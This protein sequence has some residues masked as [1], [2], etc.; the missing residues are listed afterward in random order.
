MRQCL[1]KVVM[2][3]GGNISRGSPVKMVKTRE[4][5]NNGGVRIKFPTT[6]M[7]LLTKGMIFFWDIYTQCRTATHNAL[8]EQVNKWTTTTNA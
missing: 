2:G 4:N 6:V 3:Q 7:L 8:L 5:C 1:G